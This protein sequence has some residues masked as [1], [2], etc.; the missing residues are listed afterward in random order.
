MLKMSATAPSTPKSRS[1][2]L[3]PPSSVST[4]AGTVGSRG[5]GAGLC[6]VGTGPPLFVVATGG[7]AGTGAVGETGDE[8][9]EV[10]LDDEHCRFPAQSK[11]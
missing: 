5:V 1:N 9:R 10:H 4:S 7:D 6:A 3:S 8:T 2:L 11:S